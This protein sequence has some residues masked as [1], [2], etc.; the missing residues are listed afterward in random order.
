MNIYYYFKVIVFIIFKSNF[1][2]KKPKNSDY[3]LYDQGEK[4]NKNIQTLLKKYKSTILYVRFEE[5]NLYVILIIIIKFRFFNNQSFFQNYLIEFCK[6]TNAKIVISSTLWDEKLFNLREKFRGK[7]KIFLVQKFPVKK[8]FFS[9]FKKKNI[10]DCIFV[11]DD[12]SIKILKKYFKS[13]YKKI[14]IIQ[15]NSHKKKLYKKVN[16]KIL[17]ISGYRKSFETKNP[18]FEWEFNLYHERNLVKILND[19]KLNLIQFKI[20]LKP[21]VNINDYIN[22]MNCNKYNLIINHDSLYKVIHRFD[23][24]ILI[25]NGT[26]GY[27]AISRGIKSI[28]ISKK[29][30]TEIDR[31][32]VFN[33]N[34]NNINL[35]S[36]IQK[37]SN[38]STKNFFKIC[39][40]KKIDTPIFDY[41]NTILKKFLIGQIKD[42]KI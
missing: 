9:K 12:Y 27:E 34:Y 7:I 2:F 32:Y 14:G 8:Y 21:R 39:K 15:N 22:F 20:L 6:C 18:I 36:F 29:K 13:N 37:Y 31:F 16:K 17:L 41:K 30:F 33:K 10:V 3:I 23:L 28:Q 19:L 5:I 1:K 38:F 42:I 35:K 26:V 24:I 4:F 40:Q 11:F 25:N